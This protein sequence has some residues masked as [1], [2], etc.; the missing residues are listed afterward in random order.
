MSVPGALPTA[1]YERF[2]GFR[3]YEDRFDALIPA[4]LSV[5]RIFDRQLPTRYNERGRIALLRAFLRGDPARRVVIV[6]HEPE[7]L[8]RAC[9]RLL[10]LAVELHPRL[11]IRRTLGSARHAHDPCIVVDFGHY[12]HR[13]HHAGMRAAQGWDDLAG[14]QQLIDRFGELR[15]S[16]TP[17]RAGRPAGL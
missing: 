8:V 10:E 3:E 9:P 2:E 1:R 6:V 4:A 13:F 11:E 14:A 17:V 5:I 15:E 16:S 12:L 7:P